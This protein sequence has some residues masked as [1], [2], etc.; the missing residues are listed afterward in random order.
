MTLPYSD[1]EPRVLTKEEKGKAIRNLVFTITAIDGI[2]IV[3]LYLIQTLLLA[4]DEITTLFLFIVISGTTG[5][6]LRWKM[7][8]IANE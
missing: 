3:V 6:Y 8:K 2:A 1:G 7:K 5:L 4:W